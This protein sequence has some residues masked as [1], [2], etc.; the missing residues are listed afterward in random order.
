MVFGRYHTAS[1]LIDRCE[2]GVG[3]IRCLDLV[4][5]SWGL[6]LKRDMGSQ[7]QIVGAFRT[8][9]ALRLLS[10][11]LGDCHWR[12]DIENDSY[13]H[14]VGA[15]FLLFRCALHRGFQG[16]MFHLLASEIHCLDNTA[17]PRATSRDAGGETS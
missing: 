5:A 4:A 16:R 17:I 1:L 9:T 7:F 6:D 15:H 8:F 10:E 2:C 13:C 11:R 3:W 14:A 12:S